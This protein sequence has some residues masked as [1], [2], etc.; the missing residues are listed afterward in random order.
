M[1]RLKYLL[2]CSLLALVLVLGVF[3]APKEYD[4]TGD[5]EVSLADIVRIMRATVSD[6]YNESADAN[7][8]GEVTIVDAILVLKCVVNGEGGNLYSTYSYVDIVERMTDTRI[9]AEGYSGEK[10]AEF[11][12]YSR[13][14]VYENGVYKNWNSNLDG[15]TQIPETDDGGHLVADIEGAGYISRIW[16]AT[17]GTGHIKIY[18]DGATTPI[19]D[20]EFEDFF[21]RT[22]AP[23]TYENLVYED[24]A[25]GKNTYVPITFAKSCRIVA[26]GG[27]YNETTNP[28]GWG[29]YYHVNYT[30]FP[31]GTVVESMP[32]TFSTKQK[33][34]LSAVDTFFGSKI[35]THPDG[36][37]DAAFTKHNVSSASP[38]IKE[39]SG[40]GAISGLLVRINSIDNALPATAL[41]AIEVLKGL[42]IRIYWDGESEPSVDVPLGDF[43]G[44]S[45]GFDEIQTLL[46]GV[47]DDRT[48]YN[49]FY[50][51]YLEGAKIEISA[52]DGITANI[53]VSVNTVDNTVNKDSML[54]YNSQFS[55]GEYAENKNRWPDHRFLYA[56][57]EGR[58]VGL[59]LHMD[60]L[61]DCT[62]P[63]SGLGNLWWGEGDEKFFVDGEK[64]PSWYGTGTEDFFGYAWCSDQIFSRA[65]H[66]QA[67]C[68]GRS[69]YKGNRVMTRIMMH[70][71]VPF[72]SSFDGYL[73][74]YYA[75]DYT[76]VGYTSHF[77]LDKNGTTN[78][79]TY[80][81][82]EIMSYFV[83]DGNAYSSNF[84]EAE[85][86]YVLSRS[87]SLTSYEQNMIAF[88]SSWSNVVQLTCNGGAVGDSIELIL[89]AE[90][91]GKYMLLASFTKATGYGIVQTSVNGANVGAPVD[92]YS[93][94]VSADV[95]YELGEVTLTKGFTN[96]IA[97]T[98]AGKNA[99]ARAQNFGVDFVIVV[100]VSKY[101]K[102]SSV[103]LSQYTNVHRINAKQSGAKEF[104]YE[105]E[106]LLILASVTSGSARKQIMTSYGDSWSGGEQLY[107]TAGATDATMTVYAHVE[108]AGDYN[109][110]GGFTTAKNYGKVDIYVNGTKVGSTLDL[111]SASVGYT[112][113]N[114][115]KV[116]MKAGD[117]KIV[118][119]TVGKNASSTGYQSGLDYIKFTEVEG[120]YLFEG[121]TDLLA[122][123]SVTSGS[124]RSQTMSAWGDGWSG[125]GQLFWTVSAA[126]NTLTTTVSVSKAGTYNI[127]G[128]FTAAKDY[129]I[130]DLYI[131][132]TKVGTFDGYSASVTHMTAAFGS[133]T[134]NAGSNTIEFKIT[135]K[136]ASAT[137]H[138]VGI[139]YIKLT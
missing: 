24:A 28:E 65:Y 57:G 74:K 132:G 54:Y 40:A 35:G 34:A 30:L 136:N 138:Y 42:H 92:L 88:G 51:P 105:G 27:F 11:T 134:L 66:S 90:A 86:L 125:G 52:K 79:E 103:D 135:G 82:E 53:S 56:E 26:Y 112:T 127:S 70:D 60:Q 62:D 32:K 2:T 131:N 33:A 123:A 45:Y 124:T 22:A 25:R 13:T 75:D 113:K 101:N 117:N 119:K 104:T 108:K 111:Y 71:S 15:G 31:E 9:L 107:W 87:G 72:T 46:L 89:P 69:S 58:L 83:P 50:M 29:K 122:N 67:Y 4:A 43:F 85:Q 120:T 80:T 109:V 97:F 37:A 91:D 77:Y 100:P 7:R 94:T 41:E 59:T 96:T 126:D 55:L 39:F 61:I 118:I 78:R 6:T 64:F 68:E 3:A 98:V 16:S 5:G 139:D 130:I 81:D 102:T 106:D 116:T 12:S 1:S 14:S 38:V 115:G 36:Y 137:K 19:I 76:S 114:V 8:D 18:I 99:S 93:P 21:N 73:E 10:S 84:T 110:L 20:L 95:L 44:S 133:A 49:Y 48:L 47:R 121:E 128:G 17:A 23:F 63:K 129:G